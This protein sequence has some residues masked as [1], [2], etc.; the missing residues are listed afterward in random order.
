MPVTD[1]YM[2]PGDF[3]VS[4]GDAAP[5]LM[6][7]ASDSFVA[8]WGHIVITSQY[9]GDPRGFTDAAL[10]AGAR[11][12]GVMYEPEWSDGKLT[13]Y[14]AGLD[15]HLGDES[16]GIGPRLESGFS[17][18]GS[19]LSAALSGMLPAGLTAGSIQ[20]SGSYS[21]SHEDQMCKTAIVA[22]MRS[23][24]A[25]YRIKPDGTVDAELVG[26]GNVFVESPEVVVARHNVGSDALW[27]GVPSRELVSRRKGR[28]YMTRVLI[29]SEGSNTG[30]SRASIPYYTLGGT[31]LSRVGVDSGSGAGGVADYAAGVLADHDV[32]TEQ[33]VSLDQYEVVSVQASQGPVKPGDVVYVWDPSSG[34]Y[35]ESNGPLWFRGEAIAPAMLRVAESEWP[36]V[37]GM[38]VYYR[39]SKASVTTEDWVDLT[40]YVQWEATQSS[41]GQLLRVAL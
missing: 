6:D 21:G 7:P 3:R 29:G 11:Y 22:L 13:L 25:H 23:L 35:D 19:N 17:F 1:A 24:E 10:L 33:Q 16:N 40:P 32:Q 27:T 9:L 2:A 39:P 34:F 18:S 8:E 5:H 28:D 38:G 4:L 31:A 41:G 20:A 26:T 15:L 30:V 37:D 14:G 36:L 12:T